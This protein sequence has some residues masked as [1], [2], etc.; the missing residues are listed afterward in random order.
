MADYKR[1][2]GYYYTENGLELVD[3]VEAREVAAKVKRKAA[4]KEKAATRRK[5]KKSEKT[6]SE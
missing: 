4:A 3:V 2:G 5:A 6:E 1:A